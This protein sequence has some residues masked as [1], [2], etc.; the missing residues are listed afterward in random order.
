MRRPFTIRTRL[1]LWYGAA[2]GITVVALGLLVWVSTAAVLRGSVDEALR[3]QAADV[4]AGLDRGFKVAV[5]R[6]DPAQPGIF[7]AIFGQGGTVQ[8][9]SSGVPDGLHPPAAGSS[10]AQEQT[11][12]PRLGEGKTLEE[13]KAIMAGLKLPYPKFIDHAVPGNRQCGVCPH[14]L[15]EQLAEYCMQMGD[16]PQG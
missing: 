16:S 7:T 8:V 10:V 12:N 4:R 11:R 1:T 9:R 5:T 13:F 3:V 14:D 6:L 15:P 2:L